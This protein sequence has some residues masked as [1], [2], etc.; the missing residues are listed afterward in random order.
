MSDNSRPRVSRR[1]FLAGTAAAAAAAAVP[2]IA[3]V[4]AAPPAAAATR[5]NILLRTLLT[6]DEGIPALAAQ[7]AAD[8]TA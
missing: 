6:V 5:P 4:A 3:Q 1:G 8:R 7:L 2:A